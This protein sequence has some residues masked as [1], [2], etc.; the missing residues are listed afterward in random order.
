L[1]S[2]Y[3][4]LNFDPNDSIVFGIGTRLLPKSNL[5]LF[6]VKDDRLQTGQTV[7][8]LVWRMVPDEFQRWTVDLSSK[9]GRATPDD[10]PVSG[11]ALAVT[12][13]YR[14]VFVHLTRDRKVNFSTEDQSRVSVGLRF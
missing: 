2:A 10:E 1:L 12:Y 4:N 11:S 8:H 6:T 5:S 9:R 3:Y 14:D 7:T 13:D